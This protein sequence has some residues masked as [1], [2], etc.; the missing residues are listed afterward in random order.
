[1]RRDDPIFYAKTV[2]S[3]AQ[4]SRETARLDH[5]V[6]AVTVMKVRRMR[7]PVG[8]RLVLVRVAMRLAGWVFG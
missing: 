2:I 4:V 3:G 7:M 6:M 5:A 8:H 1:M